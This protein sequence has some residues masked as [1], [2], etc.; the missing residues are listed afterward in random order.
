MKIYF[1]WQQAKSPDGYGRIIVPK[2]YGC[3]PFIGFYK[4]IPEALT[5]YFAK[6]YKIL[7]QIN[8]LKRCGHNEDYTEYWY[9]ADVEIRELAVH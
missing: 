2:A 9:E 8:Y 5:E 4:S 7:E 3:K 6:N 1:Y